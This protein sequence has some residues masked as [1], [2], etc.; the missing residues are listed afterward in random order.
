[1]PVDC[2]LQQSLRLFSEAGGGKGCSREQEMVVATSC[3]LGG[4]EHQPEVRRHPLPLSRKGQKRN[5]IQCDNSNANS[6]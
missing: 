6:F 2:Q 3:W 1:M 5:R 4:D